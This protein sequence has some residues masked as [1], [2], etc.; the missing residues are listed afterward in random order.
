MQVP[1]FTDADNYEDVIEKAARGLSVKN[2]G[3]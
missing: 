2:V 1:G 3:F